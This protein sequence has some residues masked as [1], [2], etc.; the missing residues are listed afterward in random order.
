MKSNECVNKWLWPN[1]WLFSNIYQ[2]NH[3]KV[4]LSQCCSGAVGSFWPWLR[5]PGWLVPGVSRPRPW[6]FDPWKWDHYFVSKRRTLITQW[7]GV[8]SHRNE[9]LTKRPLRI[10]RD[11]F[12][13]VTWSG[14]YLR[15]WQGA[16]CLYWTV[17]GAVSTRTHVHT[18]RGKLRRHCCA[19]LVTYR[20]VDSVRFL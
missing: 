9:D 13:I 3:E 16:V 15:L 7:R 1:L 5:L 4:A 11:P 18:H 6:T 17:F 20:P 14:D 12:D 2:W 8:I 10:V 19:G